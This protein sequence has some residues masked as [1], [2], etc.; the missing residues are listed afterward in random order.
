MCS[1]VVVK[2]LRDFQSG[3]DFFLQKTNHERKY[4]NEEVSD[5]YVH[6]F[7]LVRCRL[8]AIRN[9]KR[10]KLGPDRKRPYGR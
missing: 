5:S 8:H 4:Y 7:R 3:F 1:V 2:T 10:Q 9:D 6:G